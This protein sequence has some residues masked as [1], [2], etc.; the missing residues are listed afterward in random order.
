MHISI[1]LIYRKVYFRAAIQCAINA[2]RLAHAVAASPDLFGIVRSLTQARARSDGRKV[3]RFELNADEMRP[4]HAALLNGLFMCLC[5]N[6]AAVT[7][8][9]IELSGQRALA[10]RFAWP[11]WQLSMAMICVNSLF[12]PRHIRLALFGHRHVAVAR[13]GTYSPP[14]LKT[15]RNGR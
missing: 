11:K 6:L 15:A 12:V 5:V 2:C 7:R 13:R 1:S 14:P 4:S 9:E 10:V 3:H 8:F